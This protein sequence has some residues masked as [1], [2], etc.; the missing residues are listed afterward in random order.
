M[1]KNQLTITKN[2]F[3]LD[4][5]WVTGFTDAEG[6]FIISI[7]KNKTN[8]TKWRVQASF[9]IELHVRDMDL[10]LQIKSFFN[11][12][13]SIHIKKNISAVYHVRTLDSINNLIIPHFEKYPLI[14][15]KYS[16]FILFKDIVKLMN[17]NEH[18]N[19]EGLSK[20]VSLKAI[21]NNGLSKAI[22][23]YFPEVKKVD[24]IKVNLPTIINYYWIAGFISGD[25]CFYINILKSKDSK[26]G[27]AVKLRISI[28]QHSKDELLMNNIA[29]TLKCGY[30]Y[31]HSKNGVV[32]MI[33]TF[34][35]IYNR[36]IPLL[37]NHQIKGIKY[38]DFKDFCMTAELINHKIH[39]T[40]E[41][42]DQINKIKLGM[43]KSRI[44]L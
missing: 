21:L 11:K 5:N 3:T 29:K 41:G 12:V 7:Y 2:K 42:L 18:L 35:D 9:A 16:D 39:L 36:M 20:I 27:Y 25:G 13:G 22:I 24:R 28:T 19:K 4:P 34:K 33:Y 15:Q 17:N 31:K 8:K 23:T 37:D 30:V 38:L 44:G 40:P 26:V 1:T 10:L 6:S 43:N 32:F 14:T